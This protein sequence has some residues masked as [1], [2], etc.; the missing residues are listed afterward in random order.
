MAPG[1]GRAASA[2]GRRAGRER[3]AAPAL[4]RPT[5]RR[6]QRR[7]QGHGAGRRHTPRRGGGRAGA[8]GRVRQ[9]G[10]AGAEQ[11]R[12]RRLRRG[13]RSGPRAG[14]AV[15]RRGRRRAR[16]E[17][18]GHDPPAV[19]R[20]R[21]AGDV[22]GEPRPVA[23]GGPP[24]ARRSRLHPPGRRRAAQPPLGPDGPVLHGRAG[25]LRGPRPRPVGPLPLR[26]LGADR[27]RSGP[28]GGGRS[29]H[30][31]DGGTPRLGA[32]T[33]R[34][35]GRARP[36]PGSTRRSRAVGPAGRGCRAGGPVGRAAVDG[37]RVRGPGGGGLAGRPGRRR[38]RLGRRP[39][40]VR[41]WPGRLVGRRDR[42]V[43]TV[44]RDRRARPVQRRRALGAP[45]GGCRPGRGAAWRRVG[46]PYEEALA[47]AESDDPDD[48]RQAFARFD[49]L[50][51]RPAAATVARSMRDAGHPGVPRGVRSATAPTRPA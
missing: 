30:P 4:G 14:D 38:D 42:L 34:G 19:R 29:C 1:R 17:L 21:G 46:C 9:P 40:G 2:G 16:A 5:L 10:H 8:G 36:P 48:L 3:R 23:G 12:V 27:A 26:L 15:R 39:P 22:A 20:R 13:G 49:S 47:L 18:A 37:A 11:Q 45:A 31:A 24:R 43:A 7:R 35:I 41:R 28:V 44:R 51:A 32:P 25:V 6:A 33:D 50:G